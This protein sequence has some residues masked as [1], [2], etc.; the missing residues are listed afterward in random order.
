MQQI[1]KRP[2]PTPSVTDLFHGNDVS[3]FLETFESKAKDYGLTER[4][5]VKKLLS[6]YSNLIPRLIRNSKSFERKD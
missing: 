3:D 5:I 1:P 2:L 6:Y 4:K